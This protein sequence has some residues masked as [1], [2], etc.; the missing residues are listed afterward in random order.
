MKKRVLVG[1]GVAAVAGVLLWPRHAKKDAPPEATVKPAAAPAPSSGETAPPTPTR[2]PRPEIDDTRRRQVAEL[3]RLLHAVPEAEAARRAEDSARAAV[4]PPADPALDLA[5]QAF[6]NATDLFSRGRHREAAEAFLAAYDAVPYPQFLYNASISYE[7][8]GDCRAAL[9][10]LQR[11]VVESP[12][13]ADEG[14][15]DK[16]A[17]LQKR[18][19][20]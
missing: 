3:G 18:C 8:M 5:K 14:V 10:Y 17:G 16:L 20:P 11:F 13:A 19:G 9:E 1:V 6:A 2:H 4:P 12:D 7:K 15:K